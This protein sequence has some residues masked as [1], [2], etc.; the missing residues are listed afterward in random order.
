MPEPNWFVMPSLIGSF[1]IGS[2]TGVALRRNPEVIAKRL[3][4]ATVLVDVPTS[5][6]F[7]LNETGTRIWE[8]LGEGLDPDSIMHQLVNEFEVE[9][10]QAEDE[11]NKLLVRLRTEGLLEG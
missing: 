4:K 2:A 7:E 6:I 5:R 9:H 3:D 11:V 8:L 1:L 10:A